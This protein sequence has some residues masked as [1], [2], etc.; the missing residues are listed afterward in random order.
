MAA[1]D[2]ARFDS[3]ALYAVLDAERR[4]RGMS[5]SQVAADMGVR[6]SPSTITRTAKGGTME[7]DGITTMLAWLGLPLEAFLRRPGEPPLDFMTQVHAV[8]RAQ[9]ELSPASAAEFEAEIRTA[10]ER[11]RGAS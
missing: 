1:A 7:G 11:L 2:F 4:H 6:I 10:Y 8:L 5:W 9:R 3:P